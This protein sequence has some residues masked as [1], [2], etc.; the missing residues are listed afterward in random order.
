MLSLRA[1]L[2]AA[3][4]LALAV[5]L[6]AGGA[7]AW[8]G[9]ARSV[10]AELR[11]ALDVAR[12]TVEATVAGTGG[13]HPD[14]VGLLASFHGSRHLRATLLG[15]DGVPLAPAVVPAEAAQALPMPGFFARLL[16]ADTPPAV[17][18]PLGGGTV[19]V[20]EADPANEAREAWDDLSLA[21]LTLGAFVVLAMLCIA[22]ALAVALRPLE[23]LSAT[24]GRIGAGDFA[25]LHLAQRPETTEIARL[26][27]GFDHMTARLAAAEACDRRLRERLVTLRETERAAIARDLHDEIGPYLFAVGVDAASVQRQAGHLAPAAEASAITEAARNIAEAAA[28][29]QRGVR[30]LLGRLRPAAPLELGLGGALEELLAFWRRRRPEITW[31]LVFPPGSEEG[32][33]RATVLAAYRVA[34]EA[35]GNVARH[36]QPS[37][38]RVVA[39]QREGQFVLEVS[40]DGGGAPAA[41]G[42]GL[43][44]HGMAERVESLGGHFEWS[45][46]PQHGVTLC[47]R[48]PLA[49]APAE[50]AS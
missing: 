2:L 48:I 14:P 1:R 41:R 46:A 9:A 49:P 45:S 21:L 26:C 6:C 44:L 36:C 35:L 7:V 50:A 12:R 17:R 43:G 5:S 33:A 22:R 34:Q 23:T 13:V 16:G 25:A 4:A 32:L 39:G 11:A 47:A 28:H 15:A 3:M 30:S 29:A 40:D 37:R 27:D 38:V 42:K 18:L 8:L 31:E 24:C 19:L 10:Q 20:L